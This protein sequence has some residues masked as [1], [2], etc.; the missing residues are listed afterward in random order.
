MQTVMIWR[1]IVTASK[2][3]FRST[4]TRYIPEPTWPGQK[5]Y[6]VVFVPDHWVFF[7]LQESWYCGPPH[8]AALPLR[9]L[10]TRSQW[11]DELWSES[12]TIPP[13]SENPTS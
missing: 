11:S 1:K 9:V 10:A 5:P 3:P 6:A 12:L 8:Q 2:P 4:R 7:E 13:E